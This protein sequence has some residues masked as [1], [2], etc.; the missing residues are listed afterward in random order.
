MADSFRCDVR[1][2]VGCLGHVGS[3]DPYSARLEV[4]R[5]F[6]DEQRHF[7]LATRQVDG[8]QAI[9]QL[10][11]HSGEPPGLVYLE[12]ICHDSSR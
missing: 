2:K 10:I 8:H 1:V 11:V 6:G 9:H 3:L 12:D 4:D 7:Q 5:G